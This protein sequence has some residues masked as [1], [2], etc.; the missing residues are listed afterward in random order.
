MKLKKISFFIFFFNFQKSSVGRVGKTKK[1]KKNS[2]LTDVLLELAVSM[3]ERA[4]RVN[5]TWGR[6]FSH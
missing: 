4:R 6:M 3:K 2:G 1:K 5:Q